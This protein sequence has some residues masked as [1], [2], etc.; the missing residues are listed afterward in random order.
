MNNKIFTALLLLVFGLL[1]AVIMDSESDIDDPEEFVQAETRVVV[2]VPKKQI[3]KEI[4]KPKKETRKIKIEDES[5]EV[6][7]NT[8]PST[9]FNQITEVSE[10]KEVVKE[11]KEVIKSELIFVLTVT[12][13]NN[14]PLKGILIQ[15][16]QHM[17]IQNQ[18]S[19]FKTIRGEPQLKT[20]VAGKTKIDI[21]ESK[22]L[23][24]QIKDKK[25]SHFEKL[26]IDL[27]KE[28]TLVIQLKRKTSVMGR[29]TNSENGEGVAN[30]LITATRRERGR[31]IEKISASTNESGEYEIFISNDK[32]FYLKAWAKSY[33]IREPIEVKLKKSERLIKNFELDPGRESKIKLI[34]K[35][36]G[37]AI[38]NLKITL[39]AWKNNRFWEAQSYTEQSDGE[40]VVLLKGLSDSG[41][42]FRVTS[43]QYEATVF[44]PNKSDEIR[45]VKL[46][47]GGAIAVEVKDESGEIL[48]GVQFNQ[49]HYRGRH[50]QDRVQR[51]LFYGVEFDDESQ[52]YIIEGLRSKEYSINVE[53]DGY[54][55]EPL[56]FNLEPSQKKELSVVLKDAQKLKLL[57][58]DENGLPYDGEVKVSFIRFYSSLDNLIKTTQTTIDEKIHYTVSRPL[59]ERSFQLYVAGYEFSQKISINQTENH[60]YKINLKKGNKL[61]G[62]IYD[63]DGTP[64]VDSEVL[65]KKQ[66]YT[67]GKAQSDK[68]GFYLFDSLK[69]GKYSVSVKHS[70]FELH[71][72]N[73]EIYEEIHTQDFNLRKGRS[74]KGLVLLPDGLPAKNCKVSYTKPGAASRHHGESISTNDKGEFELNHL[75]PVKI[76]FRVSYKDYV[77]I[78]R[79]IDLSKEWPEILTFNLSKGY[80]LKGQLLL[81]ELPLPNIKLGIYSAKRSRYAMPK[82][83]VSGSNGEFEVSSLSAETYYFYLEHKK[84]TLNK[85]YST[86]IISDVSDF[87]IQVEDLKMVKG[88]VFLPDGSVAKSYDIYVKQ[89]NSSVSRRVSVIEKTEEAGFVIKE[90]SLYLRKGVNYQLQAK[91][92]NYSP[93]ETEVFNIDTVP[94][95]LELYLKPEKNFNFEITDVNARAIEN[96]KLLY[97]RSVEN[98]SLGTFFSSNKVQSDSSGF[99]VIKNISDGWYKIKFEHKDYAQ[100]IK[101][102]HLTAEN[103]NETQYVKLNVGSKLTAVIMSQQNEI[104]KNGRVW[105]SPKDAKKH[106]H[107]VKAGT[108]GEFEI[109][110][111]GSGEYKLS[112]FPEKIGEYMSEWGIPVDKNILIEAGSE[113]SVNLGG[114]D[115]DQLGGIDGVIPEGERIYSV[116]LK[117]IEPKKNISNVGY[118]KSSKFYF[119]YLMPG[120]YVVEAR[121]YSKKRLKSEEFFV[122]ENERSVV[123]LQLP[124]E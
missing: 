30:A 74:L 60:I 88:Q 80:T 81:N 111:I 35:E 68:K 75:G 37:D 121:S 99:A 82:T 22:Y 101:L 76:T 24:L 112:Y 8:V 48:E 115:L 59:R 97:I 12:D 43:E 113:N 66:H 27:E 52:K 64:I 95:E 2:E 73:I 102:F 110:G 9:L 86:K 62:Y 54:K 120:K 61:S 117:S 44:S 70:D 89:I 109:N 107:F 39:N 40:G 7:D 63:E 16:K 90:K 5:Y 57:V 11:E 18:F 71:L 96:V 36:S 85:K 92:K 53:K 15:T 106:S 1:I 47:R 83:F 93:V 87:I 122:K 26:N 19:K 69:K 56:K 103:Q 23:F 108:S 94:R 114:A 84:Y 51:M 79:V 124:I 14:I 3:K 42:E 58:L 72:S 78:E 38:P 98:S 34:A 49:G 65:I 91:A 31:G 67:I 17:E 28:Q 100:T 118:V 46:V 33:I 45:E 77:K 32:K 4:N 20:D 123:K 50:S 10:K 6:A 29:I 104:M 25:Y 105:L 21:A 13:E 116:V 119:N 55:S 41:D